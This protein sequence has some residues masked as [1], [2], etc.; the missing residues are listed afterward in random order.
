MTYLTIKLTSFVTKTGFVK[1][2]FLNKQC[3]MQMFSRLGNLDMNF[4][5]IYFSVCKGPLGEP[6]PVS[7]HL[8]I[9]PQTSFKE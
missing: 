2:L 8:I 7:V 1:I 4:T 6:M 5:H 9:Q 3:I